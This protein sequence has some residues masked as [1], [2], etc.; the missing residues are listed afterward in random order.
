MPI[1]AARR[2]GA[3]ALLAVVAG[4]AFLGF[5]GSTEL[6]GKRE[7][8]ASAEAL[9]TVDRGH[10]LV[11]EIQGRPRLEKPPLPRWITA[12]PD[13]ADRPSR[14]GDRP[15]AQRPGGPGDGGA[16]LPARAGARRPAGG[17]GL[18]LRAGVLDL[19][20]GRDAAGGQ[21]RPPGPVHDPRPA[22]R[23]GAAPRR[24]AG[25]RPATRPAPGAGRSPSTWRWAWGS[26][27]RGRSILLMAGLPVVGYL[28]TAR[29]LGPGLRLLVDARGLALFAALAL[30]WPVPVLLRDPAAARVWWLEI[31]Q[32][33]GASAVGHGNG[34]GALALDWFWMTLPW[35][36]LALLAAA[37]PLRRSAREGRPRAR[38]RLVVGDGQPG[39]PRAL[40]GG[41]A[42]LLRALPARRGAPGRRRSGS[43]SP[44]WPG[45]RLAGSAAARGLIQACWVVAVRRGDGGPGG[46]RARSPRSTWA[47]RGRGPGRGGVG[48]GRGLGLA[49]GVRRR[50]DGPAGLGVRRGR[51]DRLR[52]RRPAREPGPGP[53]GAGRGARAGRPGRARRPSGSSTSWTRGSGSTSGGTTSPRSRR[54]GPVQPGLRPPRRRQAEADRLARPAGRAGPRAARRLGQARRPGRALRPDPGQGLRPV[55]PR[56]R[57]PGRAGLPRARA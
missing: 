50:V 52:G 48:R 47:G 14:R 44:G 42:E 45:R 4:A 3:E 6:W 16:G 27:P 20:R 40:D 39:G 28:A 25:A 41:Q 24:R 37:W 33:T 54:P 21:R 26:W 30:A 34:R 9:D 18:G 15:P 32:K 29:R 17:A 11:A 13:R 19:L 43:G 23:L 2:W 12:A 57:P 1:E 56:P 22:G 55:R 36:P 35:T 31:A 53:S 8:R 5:L 51:A 10:W 49:A 46:G 38:V 7:Q